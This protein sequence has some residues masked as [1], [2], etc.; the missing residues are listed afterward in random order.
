MAEFDPITRVAVQFQ[1]K[2]P[3]DRRPYDCGQVENLSFALPS[4]SPPPA[5]LIPAVGDTVI[6][7][8]LVTGEG[9]EAYKVLTRNFSYAEGG[10]GLS[11]SV[12]IVVGDVDGNEMG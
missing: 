1:Y 5:L 11:V 3:N 2:G 10:F 4:G 9:N 7:T 8:N 12:N 6:L